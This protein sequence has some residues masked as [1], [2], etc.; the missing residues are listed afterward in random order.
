MWNWTDWVYCILVDIMGKVYFRGGKGLSGYREIFRG[1][2]SCP[3]LASLRVWKGKF[4]VQDKG[5]EN[6]AKL[7]FCLGSE[8]HFINH[9]EFN[10]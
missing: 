6:P 9:L 8:W 1:E 10:C 2:I 7:A 3:T 5:R 4:F